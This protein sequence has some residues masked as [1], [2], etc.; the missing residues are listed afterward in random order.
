[1]TLRL[2]SESELREEATPTK[3][4]DALTPQTLLEMYWYMLLSR[5]LDE[6]C[7]AMH[8]QGKIAFHISGMG[9]EATQIGAAFAINRGVD[10]VHPYYRDL[11][12]VLALGVTPL[13]FMM[14]LYGKAGE[15]SS[16]GRQ[17]PSHWSSR[18]VNLLSSSSPVATQVP[19]AAG[20]AFA[21][22]Y[23]WDTKLVDPNDAT[24]PRVAITCL[25]EGSTSQGEWHEGM[26]WAGVHKL[27]FICIVQNNNYAISVPI[28]Q[29]MAVHNVADRADAYGVRGVT[30]DG[31]DLLQMYDVMKEAVNRAYRGDG[32]TLIEAK[33]YRLT[34]HSSDDDDRTYRSREEVEGW[35]LKDPIHH[36]ERTLRERGLLSEQ[37]STDYN[38]R[39]KQ[40]I[41]EAQRQAEQMPYPPEEMLYERLYA[42]D[43]VSANG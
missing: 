39:A 20:L 29:Q 30:A 25:G 4:S 33:T 12:L 31:N 9:H 23:K 14:S 27:P 17:M 11:A 13:D 1:M 5:R 34:P 16:G 32:A 15:Y 43:E 36:F 6:R 18:K 37:E 28:D 26:N 42:D 21:I 35:K 38:A 7:W 41:D 3:P 19:Q 2:P 22:K 24:Q 40:M 10:Y 8:R